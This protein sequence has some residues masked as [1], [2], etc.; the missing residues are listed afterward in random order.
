M[1]AATRQ[2]TPQIP[3]YA[4]ILGN[5]SATQ[6][7]PMPQPVAP[8]PEVGM[9]GNLPAGP[10]SPMGPAN[11]TSAQQPQP[12]PAVPSMGIMDMLQQIFSQQGAQRNWLEQ[13]RNPNGV[14]YESQAG[15]PET[16]MDFY[17]PHGISPTATAATA[18][19]PINYLGLFGA[20]DPYW[21]SNAMPGRFPVSQSPMMQMESMLQG[22]PYEQYGFDQYKERINTPTDW[23][24]VG[25]H[26]Y[27]SDQLPEEAAAFLESDILA[28]LQKALSGNQYTMSDQQTI[29]GG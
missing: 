15:R 23:I 12:T 6:P 28:Q 20:Q 13:Q 2:Q 26:Y 7:T 3:A 25:A 27:P 16:L 19:S 22:T 8:Q 24:K 11:A 5:V 17:G 18:A 29:E 4:G 14:P 1:L 21:G 10:I 9:R